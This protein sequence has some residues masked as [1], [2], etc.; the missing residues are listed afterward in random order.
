MFVLTDTTHLHA[1]KV[2][3]TFADAA[4]ALVAIPG[5]TTPDDSYLIV[6]EDPDHPG[7][8]DIFDCGTGNLFTIEPE[9]FKLT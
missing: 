9:G 7:C 8:F 1:R 6:E 3:G 5:G 4:S 2:V